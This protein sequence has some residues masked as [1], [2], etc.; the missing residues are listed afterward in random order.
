MMLLLL[1]INCPALSQVRAGWQAP[2]PLVEGPLAIGHAGSGFLTQFRP[3]NPL[4]PSSKQSVRRALARGADGVEVDV[5]L[6]QDSEAI[7]Y[8]DSQLESMTTGTG[9]VSQT[10]ARAL[11]QLDY[12]VSWPYR[13]F[14]PYEQ[15]GRLDSLLV[16]LRKQPNFPY[17]HLDLHEDDLCATHVLGEGLIREGI[18]IGSTL[19]MVLS[20]IVLVMPAYPRWEGRR[21]ITGRRHMRELRQLPG[22]RGVG[23]W[24]SL[25]TLHVKQVWA[26]GQAVPIWHPTTT[27]LSS[28]A[29]PIVVVSGRPAE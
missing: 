3:F 9:C 29:H 4:P 18:L 27:Q 6:S 19:A 22:L 5:R 14:Q 23:E 10:P 8:H 20:I 11:T 21:D 15:V 24:Y 12:R 16:Y 28:L 13:W 2:V 1:L 7:L 26:A 25:D 17:L